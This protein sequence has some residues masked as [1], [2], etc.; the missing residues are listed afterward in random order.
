M[1]ARCLLRILAVLMAIAT[2]PQAALATGWNDFSLVVAPG[3]EI[4]RANAF[5]V[6][7]WDTTKGAPIY[8]PRDG[9]KKG[10]ITG[11]FVSPTCIF[12]KTTG[13]RPR[14]LF[15]GDTYVDADSSIE[16]FFIVDRSTNACR[17]PLT[18]SELEADAA[19]A[20][21]WP[22]KWMAPKHP[23]PERAR[24]SQLMFLAF[25]AIVFGVPLLFAALIVGLIV[26]RVVRLLKPSTPIDVDA[27][28]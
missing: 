23:H 2:S 22:L 12:L 17:G 18:L 6:G 3:Y 13:Q 19:V 21:A 8:I 10:P 14:N 16:Y 26:T 5:D 24:A 20:S 7:L 28:T 1:I 25:T 11:Y 9:S 27:P 4:V 15:R